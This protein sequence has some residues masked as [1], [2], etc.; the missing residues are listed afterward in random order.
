MSLQ[1]GSLYPPSGNLMASAKSF[2]LRGGFVN[3]L[4][5]SLVGPVYYVSGNASTVWGPVGDDGNNGLSPLTPLAT[6]ARAFALIY[7]T[8]PATVEQVNA[9]V[10]LIGTIREQ[11]TAPLVKNVTIMGA[12]P[13]PYQGTDSGADNGAGCACWLAPTSPTASTPLL[14]VVEQGWNIDSI[15]FG[16]VASTPSLRLKGLETAAFPDA[17][18]AIVNNCFFAT[19]GLTAEVGIGGYNLFKCR[20]TNNIFQGLTDTAIKGEDV[21]IRT[22]A[23]NVIQSNF[24]R[25]CANAI[26]MPM[27]YGFI[28][29]NRF[30]DTT[31]KRIDIN[32]GADNFVELNFFEDTEANIS[33]AGGYIGNASDVWRNYSTD[34]AAMTVGVPA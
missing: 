30:K 16:T 17:S 27:N 25:E 21:S 7:Q 12:Q 33:I 13:N 24:F 31:T 6:M 19:Q 32:A 11:V 18:H 29:D 26:D 8:V 4:N 15:M 3:G 10:V 28:N 1:I 23:N 2:G 22:P 5:P 9:V 20:F 34:V 14:T